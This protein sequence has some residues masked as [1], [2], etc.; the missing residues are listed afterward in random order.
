MNY[1]ASNS[2]Q[3]AT[4]IVRRLLT[5]HNVVRIRL[6]LQLHFDNSHHRPSVLL[7]S[8]K[9]TKT[10]GFKI[11]VLGKADGYYRI[12]GL[13][14]NCHVNVKPDRQEWGFKVCQYPKSTAEGL[15]RG[16][17]EVKREVEREVN[18]S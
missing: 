13:E 5:D 17:I 16:G 14:F 9:G 15:G 8:S 7:W 18:R 1:D 3:E 11:P 4:R 12:I 6:R 10:F 2:F